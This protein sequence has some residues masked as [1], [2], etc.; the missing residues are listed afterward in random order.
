MIGDCI[1]QTFQ[2]NN[3]NSISTT[4]AISVVI[5][6]FA[7]SGGERKFPLLN[8]A[9]ICGPVMMFPPP[10]TAVSQSRINNARQAISIEA[11]LD[12]QAVS[13]LYDGPSHLK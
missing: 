4:V 12:E 7:W 11:E 2:H 13:K 8:P 9:N 6:G 5:E 1:L 3:A 10:A